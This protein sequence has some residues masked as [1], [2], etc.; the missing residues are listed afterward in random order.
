MNRNI[1]AIAA[2]AVIVIMELAGFAVEFHADMFVYYTNLSNMGALIACLFLMIIQITGWKK[3]EQIALWIKY[4]VTC[5]TTVT[6]VVVICILVPMQ[7]VQ[8]LY[9][10]NLIFF[11]VLCPLLMFVSFCR[12]DGGKMNR[13]K[14]YIGVIPT[15]FYALAAIAANY[16]GVLDGPYPFL[17]V[18]RQPFYT[19]VI[20][21]IVILGLAYAFA[22]MLLAIH[23]N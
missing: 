16:A 8:L 15:L 12:L 14:G 6:L 1:K 9:R 19:S 11:H 10:G 21:F 22:A 2:N 13:R 20:W 3:G 5:M 18:T 17:R 23:K 4:L 7:G